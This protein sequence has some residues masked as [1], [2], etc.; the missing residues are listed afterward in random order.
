M[1]TIIVAVSSNM[2][3]GKEND[4]PWV[5]PTDMKHFK[6]VTTG[7]SV[8]MG[9]KCWDSIPEKFR[10]LPNRKN[11]VLTRNKDFKQDGVKVVHSLDDIL[12]KYKQSN[13]ILY[14][15]GGAE[16]YKECFKHADNMYLTD[17]FNTIDGD[18]K[19]ENLDLT[20]WTLKD[21]SD[22]IE[23]NGIK[24]TINYYERK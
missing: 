19:L 5:L 6:T 18:V 3:I 9:R 14:I 8:L 23:E 2:V 7:H 16:L 22:L 12:K 1:I 17:I 15:I 24:Y 13:E 4:L 10:P 11:Y 21:I 20:K